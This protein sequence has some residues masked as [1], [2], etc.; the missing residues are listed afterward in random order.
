MLSRRTGGSTSADVLR[1]L[2]RLCHRHGP[3]ACLRSDNGAEFTSKT[4]LR[5]LQARGTKTAFIEPGAPWENAYVES[6][7]SRLRDELLN[8]E[9][10][11]SLAEARTVLEDYRHSYNHERPHSSLGYQAPAI[12]CGGPF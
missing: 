1:V 4:V 7:L 6:F 12:Y 10:F 3:P 11:S 2:R 8:R 9:L 5:G